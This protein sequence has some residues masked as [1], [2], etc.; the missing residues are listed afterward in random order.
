MSSLLE[1][2]PGRDFDQRREDVSS[3]RRAGPQLDYRRHARSQGLVDAIDRSHG[4]SAI[5]EN[6]RSYSFS[7]GKSFSPAV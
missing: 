1:H 7:R 3:R 2:P 4:I 5:S 6:A